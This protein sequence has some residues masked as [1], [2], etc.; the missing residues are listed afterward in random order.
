LADTPNRFAVEF[1]DSLNEYQQ[2][3]FSLSDPAD[4]ARSGQEVSQTLAALGIGNFDQAARIL[5]LNLDKSVRGNTYVE[6]ETSVRSLGI[7]P[8]DLITV[9]YLKEGFTRQPFRVLKIAPGVNHRTT[10]ITAQIHDDSW[11]ADSNG[12]VTSASGGR[13][14]G[15]AGV[16]VPRPLMGSVLDDRGDIQ[17]DVQ[18]SVT[19]AG[20]G[21][22]Q[23]NVTVGFVAPSVAAAGGPGIPMV[24]L[25]AS[26]GTGGTLQGGQTLYYAVSAV[27]AAG[28][29]SSPSFVVR[30]L[31]VGDGSSVTL[32]GLSFSPG[33]AGF[34]VYRG[35]TPAVLY[36]IASNQAVAA[37]TTVPLRAPSLPRPFKRSEP[38]Q[39]PSMSQ[40]GPGHACGHREHR[41]AEADVASVP[42]CAGPLFVHRE[43]AADTN[44][45]ERHEHHRNV[46]DRPEAEA[47]IV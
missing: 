25:S 13:R 32:T 40:P 8:G 16:G 30:A 35:L 47:G 4:V 23:T 41:D 24:S 36:R 2:D 7:R 33:T 31:T 37:H 26:V 18:E 3:S 46:G 6:F 43:H 12:Q 29:E 44:R 14:L 21:T 45:D 19:T 1:Q 9:T 10:T 15:S 34:H 22:V 42:S 28:G 20:D 5:K 17:F 27:D 39:R 38:E 11:Y